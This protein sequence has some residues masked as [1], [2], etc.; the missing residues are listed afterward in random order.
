MLQPAKQKAV[1]TLLPVQVAFAAFVEETPNDA[2][3]HAQCLPGQ[4]VSDARAA[5]RLAPL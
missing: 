1:R 3:Q 5:R 4:L 2:E